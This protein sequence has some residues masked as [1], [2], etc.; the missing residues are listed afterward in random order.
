M[1]SPWILAA[2]PKT[3]PAALIPVVLGSA[4]AWRDH[5]FRELPAILCGLFALLIQIGTNYANDYYDFLR[6]ADTPERIGP[7]RMVAA[8]RIAP[9]AMR[10]GMWVVFG[11]AFVC[12][13]GLLPYG[14]WWLLP[15]GMVCILCGI[16]YTGGPYPLGYNGWG[17]VFVF[18]FFG[19]AAVSVTYYVQAGF[20]VDSLILGMVPGALSTN[21]LVVNNYRDAETDIRAGKRTLAVRWG[22]GFALWEYRF[23]LLVAVLGTAVLC[24]PSLWRWWL[25][26][27]PA[28][29]L[30]RGWSLSQRLQAAQTREQYDLVLTE[31]ARYLLVYG[32]L[33]ALMLLS[34][35]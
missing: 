24:W 9:D 12:G 13:C 1:T 33:L 6:G 8:G 2:R 14:G 17:E 7:A 19:L 26:L 15:F 16:A 25:L 10:R 31:T 30:M 29:L 34:S 4:L 27:P 23:L 11:L 20:S 18:L 32:S 35:R 5:S 22:R 28:I 3:L 21:L